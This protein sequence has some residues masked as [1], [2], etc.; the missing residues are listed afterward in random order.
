MDSV[1][2]LMLDAKQAILDDA[3]GRFI[4][5]QKE[6]RTKEAMHQF[7]VTLGCATDLLNESILVLERVLAAHGSNQD[8]QSGPPP[9]DQQG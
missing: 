6:G 5:L 8:P 4:A 1:D 3:H 7:Q 9:L 2:T